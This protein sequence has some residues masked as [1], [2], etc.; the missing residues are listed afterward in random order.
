MSNGSGV[1]GRPVAP[2]PACPAPGEDVFV[3]DNP[4]GLR[5][6]KFG[7]SVLAD[8]PAYR[9]AAEEVR[10]EVAGGAKVVVVVSAMGATTDALLARARAVATSPP[11]ALV[12]ALVATGEEASAALFAIALLAVGVPALRLSSWRLPIHTRGDLRDADPV[13]VDAGTIV[14][15]LESHDAVVLPGFVGLDASGAPSLLG[16]GGSDLTALFLGQVLGAAEV[17]LVKDVDGIYPADPKRVRGLAPFSRTTWEEARRV[18]GGVVQN[19]AL[20]YAER[21][22]LGF[23]VA[24]L[25]GGGTWVGGRPA[26]MRPGGAALGGCRS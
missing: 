21:H 9:S 15:A 11:D 16:R 19:K 3:P 8:P 24:P 23:R 14:A 7:S 5:V 25:G 12:G 17:R 18:G 13:N 2:L 22:V 6:L 1:S 10:A 20:A 4:A 26:R